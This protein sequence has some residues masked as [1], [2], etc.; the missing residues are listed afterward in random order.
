MLAKAR[1][2]DGPQVWFLTVRVA[3]IGVAVLL[4]G[5]FLEAR[6]AWT[7]GAQFSGSGP[8]AETGVSLIQRITGMALFGGYRMPVTLLVSVFALAGLLVIVHRCQPV[9]HTRVLR[10]EWLTLWAV[11]TLLALAATLVGVVALF[12]D[13]PFD[14]PDPSVIEDN[15][16]PGYHEQ[17]VTNLSWPL[18]VLLLLLPLGLW[19]A[20]L[21][22][23]DELEDALAGREQAVPGHAVP[24]AAAPFERSG[25]WRRSSTDDD[26][27]FVDD[28]EQIDP[29][30]RLSPRGADR[31]DGSSSSGYEGYFRRP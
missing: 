23:M 29:V 14:S 25:G 22:D 5:A 30:E 21:P 11:A 6:Y 13:S 8:V 18:G 26:S 12:A 9:S 4:L 24:D 10:W 17:V 1:D 20:R 15:F 3:E 27:I 19:W 2:L 7:V 31:G 28:V 16:G